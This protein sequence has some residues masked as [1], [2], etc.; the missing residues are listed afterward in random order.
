MALV[1]FVLFLCKKFLFIGKNSVEETGTK[2]SKL[3]GSIHSNLPS[4]SRKLKGTEANSIS[5]VD[6]LSIF[7]QNSRG[8]RKS[9]TNVRAE[10]HFT[11]TD[12]NDIQ[13]DS[14]SEHP[15]DF[16]PKGIFVNGTDTSKLKLRLIILV[17]VW[18][19]TKL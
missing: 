2:D 5:Y 4:D 3:R 13:T 9:V 14:V 19:L 15:R 1:I 10:D 12:D 17:F 18:M 11:E 16:S 6:K 8:K 7:K